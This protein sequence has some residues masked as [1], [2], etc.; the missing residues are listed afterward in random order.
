[1]W[2][3]SLCLELFC[4]SEPASTMLD[5]ATYSVLS[6]NEILKLLLSLPGWRSQANYQPW[7]L[8]ANQRAGKCQSVFFFDN[9]LG[10][11]QWP[12]LWCGLWP[13]NLE[14]G[15]DFP[16]LLPLFRQRCQAHRAI[17]Q[18]LSFHGNYVSSFWLR[19]LPE[20]GTQPQITPKRANAEATSTV[21]FGKAFLSFYFVSLADSKTNFCSLST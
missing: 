8:R 19:A 17:A 9:F 10:K 13:K 21:C 1:M 4:W 11:V 16:R 14:D 15:S 2:N 12:E 3:N 20:G 5:Q 6:K 18:S 7:I